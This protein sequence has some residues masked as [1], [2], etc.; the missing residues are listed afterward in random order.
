MPTLDLVPY[1]DLTQIDSPT[2]RTYITPAGNQYPSVTTVLGAKPKPEL[3]EWRARVG[4]REA[5]RITRTS[6]VAGEKL[7]KACENYLLGKEVGRLDPAIKRMFNK[8]RP[9]L[10]KIDVVRGIEIP[11]W[12]D[13]LK[14]AG[15]S[16]CIA[17][18]EGELTIIDFKNSRREKLREWIEGYFLQGTI[19]AMMFMEVYRMPVKRIAIMVATWDGQKQVFREKVKDRLQAVEELMVNYNPLWS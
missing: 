15:R 1:H 12:S 2:G 7:H 13:Y 5:D 10:D 19:Y 3:D 16:D 17:V 11:M 18:Y 9:E 14:V 4:A 6:T 8:I